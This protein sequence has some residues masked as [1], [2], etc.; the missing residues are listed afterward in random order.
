MK[1]NDIIQH[2]VDISIGQCKITEQDILEMSDREGQM[3]AMGLLTLFEEVE[4]RKKKLEDSNKEK[5]VLL[6]EIHHRV[7]NNLQIISSLLK[8]QGFFIND[9]QARSVLNDCQSRVNTMAIIHEKLYRSKDLGKVDYRDYLEELV[10]QLKSTHPEALQYLEVELN[11]PSMELDIDVAIPLGLLIN[12]ILTNSIKYSLEENS[13]NRIYLHIIEVDDNKLKLNI[14][15]NGPGYPNELFN[16][17]S[18]T[19]GVQLIHDL[20]LQLNG[21]IKK[22]NNP[23][24]GTHYEILFEDLS[25]I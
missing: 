4:Y 18:N 9:Y 19:L 12:E 6:K 17:K 20:T 24:K 25:E 2:L 21:E 3:I 22:K 1:A 11:V 10:C 13:M 8:L 7:K 23:Q 14:G 15:D 16:S 5:E